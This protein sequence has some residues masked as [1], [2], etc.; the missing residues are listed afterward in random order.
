VE[1]ALAPLLLALDPLPVLLDAVRRIGLD[2]AEDVRM[3]SDELLVNQPSRLL[4]VTAPAFLE[5]Q[6]EEVDLE[7]EIAE[8]VEELRVVVRHGGV[9]DLVCLLDRVRDDRLRRLLPVPGAVAAE[10]ASELV[11]LGQRLGE[12][13][14]P[15]M[16]EVDAGGATAVVAGGA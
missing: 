14:P 8:L 1:D 15:G 12:A 5:E 3:A 13:Q 9:G 2:V 6:G 10:A 16:T 7:E 11:E 4:E